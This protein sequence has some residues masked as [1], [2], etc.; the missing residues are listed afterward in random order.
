[1]GGNLIFPD[2]VSLATRADIPGPREAREE[3]WER[4]AQA[5][6]NAG[7]VLR[8]SD[9][10]RFRYYAEANIHAPDIWRAFILFSSA[11]LQSS[12]SLLFDFKD[13][14]PVSLGDGAIRQIITALEPHA[15]QLSHDGFVQFG[16]VSQT[17]ETLSE[18]FVAPTKHFKIWFDD[19]TAF[20]ATA[21]ELGLE[22]AERLEFIDE[23]PRVTRSQSVDKVMHAD[24]LAS[25]LRSRLAV[26]GMN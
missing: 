19:E 4:L 13:D 16:I 5:R 8:D 9:D 11:L 18:V 7:F 17:E 24:E 20:R 1:M 25:L 23:Y 14:E 6:I 21:L 3:T 10:D 26:S 2:G 12:G 15:Y 22:Q